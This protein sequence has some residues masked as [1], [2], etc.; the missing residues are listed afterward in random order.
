MKMGYGDRMALVVKDFGR[1]VVIDIQ[2][3]KTKLSKNGKRLTIS[4]DDGP[5]RGKKIR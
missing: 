3:G 1:H 2:R 4:Y 5:N